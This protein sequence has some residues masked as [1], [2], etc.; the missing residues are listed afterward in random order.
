MN[1]TKVQE[2]E[3]MTSLKADSQN[4]SLHHSADENDQDHGHALTW[5]EINRVLFVAVAAG[6]IW[7]LRGA[8]NPYITAIGV[9]LFS[10]LRM[11]LAG[12]GS[13]GAE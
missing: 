8:P 7:F 11:A 9:S 6:A 13:L 1:R 10:R 5:R 4:A 12:R 3:N 2:P